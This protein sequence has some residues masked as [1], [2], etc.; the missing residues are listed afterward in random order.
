MGH[1]AHPPQAGPGPDEAFLL[2]RARQGD[3][4]AFEEVVRRHQR[5]VYG[6]ALRIVRAH[7]VADDVAQEAFV[8]AWQS[9]D[10]FDLGR[11]FGPWVCRIAANL[12][13]NHARSPRAREQGLPEGHAETPS[14]DP[15]P[16][17]AVLDAEAKRVL[18]EAVA[19]LSPEQ[20]GVFVLRAVEEMSYEE[21]AGALGI[22]PGTVMS[23]LFRARERLARALAPYLGASAVR[24]KAGGS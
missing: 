11:P 18:D 24:R 6:V 10:R 19:G 4:G 16:L 22:S 9:L 20:R 7:D 8:R 15:G 21:I 13:V 12:A 3:L 17:G 1:S 14:A 2:A 23:R 5:R